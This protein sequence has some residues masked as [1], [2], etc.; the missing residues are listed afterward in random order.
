MLHTTNLSGPFFSAP[1]CTLRE[2]V[3]VGHFLRTRVIDALFDYLE[4]RFW[5]CRILEEDSAGLNE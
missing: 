4:F 2:N 5:I 1:S 3:T